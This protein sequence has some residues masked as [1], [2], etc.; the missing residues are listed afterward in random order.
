MLRYFVNGRCGQEKGRDGWLAEKP[1][2]KVIF[3]FLAGLA[4]V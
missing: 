4:H 1:M 3:P 2:W